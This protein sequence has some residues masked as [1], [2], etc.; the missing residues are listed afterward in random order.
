MQQARSSV[1]F[2]VRSFRGHA[3]AARR[4]AIA[5]A[6]LFAYLAGS[7]F[8]FMQLYGV[9]E[10]QYGWIFAII[11]VGII[12]TSQVNT[13]ILRK[14][15]SEKIIPV[16]LMAQSV[17]GISLAGIAFFVI[18]TPFG[19]SLTPLALA[20]ASTAIMLAVAVW[21]AV[22]LGSPAGHS[23]ATNS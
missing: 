20:A 13:F 17:I 7:P 21:E 6:G 9:S 4:G 18:L 8:V 12:T 5:S 10:K 23:D 22:S 11:A 2:S 14:Y 15:Q 3:S 19:P 16:A 1:T